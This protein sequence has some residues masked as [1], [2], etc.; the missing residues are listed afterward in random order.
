MADV[1]DSTTR[2]RMMSGIRGANTKPELVLRRALHRGGFRF[3]LHVRDLPGRPDIV[4]PRH[5]AAIFVHG[6]FWHRHR[7]CHWCST[8]RSNE[9]FWQEKF[10][11]NVERD[12]A[13]RE[14][15]AALGWRTAVVWECSLRA[16]Y[17]E[18][19]VANLASW[20]RASGETFE[21]PVLRPAS[22]SRS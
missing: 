5:H 20:I 12:R 13:T 16:P 2:S 7:G 14:K 6:C 1:V 11:G 4:L 22:D 18:T 19:A 21:T 9:A 15:L 8:P 3:R 10:A 17:A